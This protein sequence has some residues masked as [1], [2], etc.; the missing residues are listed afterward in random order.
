VA[1]STVQ[2]RYVF[3]RGLTPIETDTADFN[4]VGL[5]EM[6]FCGSL[7]PEPSTTAYSAYPPTATCVSMRTLGG[8]A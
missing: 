1:G 7:V 8:G 4:I 6:Q 3:L 5:G 2:A